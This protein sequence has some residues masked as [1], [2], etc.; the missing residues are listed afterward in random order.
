MTTET[1][2]ENIKVYESP[3]CSWPGF[4]WSI[5]SDQELVTIYGQRIW[6]FIPQTWRYWWITSAADLFTDEV[7]LH[8]P[9]SVFV[10]KTMEINEWD[11]DIES[12]NLSRLRDTTNKHLMPRVLCPWGCSE[13]YHK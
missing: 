2:K 13:H 8:H 9:Q 12:M 5:L 6:Q 3:E 1:S 11:T 4:V 7:S 10:D